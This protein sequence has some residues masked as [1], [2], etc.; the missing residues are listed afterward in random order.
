MVCVVYSIYL[1]T[2][3]EYTENS[4]ESHLVTIV[5]AVVIALLLIMCTMVLVVGCVK[6]HKKPHL[7]YFR[8]WITGEHPDLP[9]KFNEE[10]YTFKYGLEGS[11]N[12]QIIPR[13]NI[14]LVDVIGEGHFGTVYRGTATGLT[15]DEA[16]VVIAAKSLKLSTSDDNLKDFMQEARY[17]SPLSHPNIISL[18]GISLSKEPF[19][20]VFEY[21][22]EGDLRAFLQRNGGSLER[23]LMH[24]NRSKSR[25]SSSASYESPNLT[26]SQL[27]KICYQVACGMEHV[28]SHG[29]IHR[30]LAAR[31]CLVGNNLLVKIGDFGLSRL[32]YQKHFYQERNGAEVPVRWMAPEALL[33]GEFT[34]E[35]DVWSFG[36]LMWE[37][38][39]FGLLPYYGKGNEEIP[40]L[41][42][43][44]VTMEIPLNCPR[45]MYALMMSCWRLN[46]SQRPNFT[47][48]A[49]TLREYADHQEAQESAL[50]DN[51]SYP[52]D[53]EQDDVFMEDE[54]TNIHDR[55]SSS[56]V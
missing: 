36:V 39:S 1:F 16:G 10:Y 18:Y 2:F 32:L 6:F 35:C 45:S 47:E 22:P 3:L 21:M 54:E 30:D 40:N 52:S 41:I 49:V 38:F 8:P 23:R 33:R 28:A 42:M 15:E 46:S 24:L 27:M 26:L 19:F 48:L 53:F 14:N 9:Y 56:S 17:M 13:E 44:G 34:I 51:I 11:A 12:L 31:N 37:V 7:Y 5:M 4:S 25:S 50:A 20:L 55:A 29:Q 43:Q